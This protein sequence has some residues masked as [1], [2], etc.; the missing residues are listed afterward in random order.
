MYCHCAA[1]PPTRSVSNR[2]TLQPDQCIVPRL[3]CPAGTDKAPAAAPAMLHAT[4]QTRISPQS[5]RGLPSARQALAPAAWW[6][7]AAQKMAGWLMGLSVGTRSGYWRSKRSCRLGRC[8]K[9]S[10]AQRILVPDAPGWSL[11]RA[12]HP[13]SSNQTGKF[14]GATCVDARL[15]APCFAHPRAMPTCLCMPMQGCPS[16]HDCHH[17]GV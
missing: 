2:L 10:I 4:P 16:G 5:R 14:A 12:L 6:L 9:S 15:F 7:R 3:Q 11:A 8:G 17:C 1:T 13:R